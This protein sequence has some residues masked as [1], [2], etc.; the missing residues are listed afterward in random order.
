MTHENVL[1]NVKESLSMRKNTIIYTIETNEKKEENS[2][3]VYGLKMRIL[4]IE[5]L[6]R[7]LEF[8]ER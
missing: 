8:F 3:W 4:E 6:L 7:C 1:I 5:N 2:K